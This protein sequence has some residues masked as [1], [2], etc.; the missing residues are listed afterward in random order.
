MSDDGGS[1]VVTSGIA[2]CVGSFETSVRNR[3]M[4]DSSELCVGCD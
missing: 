4:S 3:L 1:T 2:D